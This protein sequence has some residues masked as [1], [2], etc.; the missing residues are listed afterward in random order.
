MFT[1]YFTLFEI[2]VCEIRPAAASLCGGDVSQRRSPSPQGWGRS[3]S[4]PPARQCYSRSLAGSKKP[5]VM[6]IGFKQD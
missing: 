1:F 5:D 6:G 3:T 2:V 4:G